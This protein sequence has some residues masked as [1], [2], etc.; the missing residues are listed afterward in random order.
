MKKLIFVLLISCGLQSFAQTVTVKEDVINADDK[1]YAKIEKAG[2][3]NFNIKNF[4]NKTLIVVTAKTITDPSEKSIYNPEGFVSYAQFVFLDSIGQKCETS[5]LFGKAE[6][7]A[8]F[9]VK[10]EFIKDG[11]LNEEGVRTF[12]LV[13][14][15]PYSDKNRR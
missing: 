7:I 8:K 13:N 12:V 11:A 4:A 3:G 1:P 15:T 2:A 6:K 5:Y 9:I 10:N 14:G